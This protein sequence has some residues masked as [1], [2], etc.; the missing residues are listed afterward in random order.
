MQERHKNRKIYFEEQGKTTAQY[1]I[2]YMEKV[3]DI[4]DQVR[5]LEI[6]CGEGGNLMPFI[7]RGCEVVGIDLNELQ[8]DRARTYIKETVP[9]AKAILIYDDM[10]NIDPKELG[11]FDLIFMRDVIEHIHDQEKFMPFLANFIKPR[12]KIF[13]GFPPWRM[14]FGGHQQ[15]CRSRFLSK[16]P[17]F[18]LLPMP[19]YKGVLQSFG[20][21]TKT[22]EDLVEIKN[23]GIS[24]QRF[25]K[26]VSES[27]YVFDRKDLFFINP[28]YEIKFGLRPRKLSGLIKPIPFVRDFFTT[29]YYCV[30]S[31]G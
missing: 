30:I 8:I 1:V 21:P 7:E 14:P 22:V 11:S 15:I 26:I 29:C 16:L 28:N 19:L 20:E 12:G 5:V 10:Y 9:H 25:E 6:G 24:I 31:K 13:F 2:P 18:H 3:M 17:F 4:N 27:G 23:T